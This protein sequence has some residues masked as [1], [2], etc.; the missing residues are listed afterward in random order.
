MIF[1]DNASTTKVLP[2]VLDVYNKYS[3]ELY[4]NPSAPYI[5]ANNVKKDILQA[6]K[7]ILKFLHATSDSKV[8][9]TSCATESNNMAILCNLNKRFKKVLLSVGEHSSIYNLSQEIKNRGFEV[10]FIKLQENGQVDEND[11]INKMSSEVGLVAIMSVSNETGAINDIE[12]LVKLVKSVNFDCYFHCDGVQAMCKIDVNLSKWGVDSFTFSGHK[13]CAPKGVAGL[14]VKK[15]IL[16]MIIGG[17]QQN[18]LRSGTENVAGIMAMT[19]AIEILSAKNAFAY[20]K[21]L[22]SCAR[23]I[24]GEQKGISINSNQENSPYILSISFAGVNG[25]TIVNMMDADGVC[26][27]TGSACTTKKAGNTTLEAMKVSQENI[28]GSVRMSFC[29][30]NTI[31]EVQFACNKLIEN[32]VKLKKI[33]GK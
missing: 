15:N 31:E 33:M 16:P 25:A 32:Y 6:E 18:G 12:K 11:L 8:I 10:D 5:C 1:L 9:F 14:I 21:E 4:F 17:G 26:L 13:I 19:K 28:M 7:F 29:F 24:L 20:V 30:S 3:T 2:E 22:N 27:G 23:K